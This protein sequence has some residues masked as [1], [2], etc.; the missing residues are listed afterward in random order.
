MGAGTYHA[1]KSGY[2][3][4]AIRSGLISDYPRVDADVTC[5]VAMVGAG[6]TGAL[7]SDELAVHGH[8]VDVDDQRE[9]GWGST[10]AST[11]Q[12]QYVI[13]SHLL[14]LGCLIERA[15]S[16]LAYLV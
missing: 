2:P 3:W 1:L 11:A 9:V 6:I 8:V 5:E 4:W 14:A 10:A 7:L 16:V 12:L 15:P 13:D